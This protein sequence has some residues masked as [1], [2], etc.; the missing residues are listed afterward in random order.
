MN[1]YFSCESWGPTET[2]KG[3]GLPSQFQGRRKSGGGE[4]NIDILHDIEIFLHGLYRIA[5][6]G[7]TDQF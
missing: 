4:V 5:K 2:W 6:E 1:R 3:S 7:G